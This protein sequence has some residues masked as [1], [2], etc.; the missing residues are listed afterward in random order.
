MY[1]LSLNNRISLLFLLFESFSTSALADGLSLESRW[2]QVSRILLSILTDLSNAVVYI[3]SPCLLISKSSS[4]C[5]NPFGTVAR[6]P[7]TVIFLFH[8]FF[9][10]LPK[11][12][13]LIF[14]FAFFQLYSVVSR[15]R[16]V[17]SSLSSLIFVDYYLAEIRWSVFMLESQLILC[18][19][20]SRT[21]SG[22]CIYHLFVWSNLNFLHSSLWITLPTQS[23]LV[24]YSFC[25]NFLHSL[26][27]SFYH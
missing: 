21:D 10:F 26:I 12:Q 13:V 23:C 5:T 17:H 3:V 15:D 6:A 19:L 7:I 22:L 24:L 2:Q 9:N 18:F 1:T 16:K 25:A 8:I 11:I 4:P 27:L 14:L 20:F